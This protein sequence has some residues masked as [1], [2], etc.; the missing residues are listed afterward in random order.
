MPTPGQ[1]ISRVARSKQETKAAYN[2]LSRWYDAL[3]GG[4]ERGCREI[5]LQKLNAG[6]RENIL[7]IGFGTGK[8][9]LALAQAVGPSGRVFGVDLSDSMTA[10]AQSRVRQA[11]LEERVDLRCGDALAL[12]FELEF[13]YAV[14]SCFTLEL[15][16]TPEIP[17]VLGEC[18]RVLRNRGRL[19]IVA[20]AV[21]E[22]PNIMTR[23]YDWA[24]RALPAYVDCR[25]IFVRQAIEDAGFQILDVTRKGMWGL[26]VEIVLASKTTQ[27]HPAFASPV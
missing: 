2:R 15:F 25:P 22:R 23:I 11:G 13:F 16:D 5:G 12:P 9:L 24:H 17:V 19:C 20:M 4:S 1:E 7:E 18:R 10:L 3:A 8:A 26:P 21:A 14:F 27:F 6:A